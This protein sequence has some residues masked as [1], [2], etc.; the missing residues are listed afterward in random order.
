MPSGR[1]AALEAVT[2]DAFGTL[3]ELRDPVPHLRD[4]LAERGVVRSTADVM[5]AF[6]AEAAFY[7]PRSHEGRDEETLAALR[8]RCAAVFL[9]DVGA[10]L[11]PGEF[12]PAFVAALRYAAIPGV[13]EAL[14]R[15]RAAG[16]ALACV[17]NWDYTL[18][19]HL[20]AA[21][22][23]S[24]LQTVVTS[25]EANAAKPDPQIFRLAL[26]RLEVEP[27]RALHVGDAPADSVGARAAGLGFEPV[28]V[29]TLPERLELG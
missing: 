13:P 20:A 12:A 14:E 8:R 11:D 26:A 18:A 1:A 15:L 21:G 28:P 22:L 24:Y 27:A 7:V 4:A 5:H 29:A 9:D 25:A 6:V 16:L 3:L 2:L 19:E 23:A 10:D 17:A